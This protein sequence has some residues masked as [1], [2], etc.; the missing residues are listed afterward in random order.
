MVPCWKLLEKWEKMRIS[1]R[2]AKVRGEL[3][4]EA[5]AGD[6]QK[7]KLL[8]WREVTRGSSRIHFETYFI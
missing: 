7:E 2:T 4:E 3:V 8:D 1:T 5:V 6:V